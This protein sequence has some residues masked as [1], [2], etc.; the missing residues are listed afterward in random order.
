MNYNERKLSVLEALADL[1]EARARELMDYLGD[2]SLEATK[3]G[4]NQILLAGPPASKKKPLQ[5]LKQGP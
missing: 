3:K 5:H 4:F 1:G 2:I